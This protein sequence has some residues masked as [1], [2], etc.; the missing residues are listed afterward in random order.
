MLKWSIEAKCTYILTESIFSGYYKLSKA[1]V[2]WKLFNT[3][4][5]KPIVPK[6]LITFLYSPGLSGTESLA[7]IWPKKVDFT[8]LH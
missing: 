1:V 8:E 5:Y 4:V 2:I 3:I 6:L 7:F